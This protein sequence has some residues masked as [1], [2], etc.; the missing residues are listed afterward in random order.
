[1]A[2]SAVL[3]RCGQDLPDTDLHVLTNGR[4]FK[5]AVDAAAWTRCRR[6]ADDLGG[7]ARR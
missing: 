4:N 2:S 3:E 1:M 5:D 6:R 7:A